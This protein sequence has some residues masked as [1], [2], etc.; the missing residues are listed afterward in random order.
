[1]SA[2]QGLQTSRWGFTI[3]FIIGVIAKL[4]TPDPVIPVERTAAWAPGVS[5][6]GGIPTNRTSLINVTNAPYN[7]KGDGV[8]DNTAAIQ[9]AINAATANQVVYLPAGRYLCTATLNLKK[10]NISIR[11]DG[12]NATIINYTGA[13]VAISAAPYITSWSARQAVTSA[14][15]QGTNQ[16]TVTNASGITVGDII[17]ISQINPS[18]ATLHGNNG[19]L[20]W[21]GAPNASGGYTNDTTRGMMQV[22]LVTAVSGNT[23]TLERPLYLTFASS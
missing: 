10:S 20:S 16:I 12:P 18:Y 14:V 21:G 4:A 5:F 2:R 11:G 8:T 17:V 3:L 1:M 9:A 19:L 6:R 22:D 7:A 15:T 23:L 13:G